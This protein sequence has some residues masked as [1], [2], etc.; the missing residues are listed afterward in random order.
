[1]DWWVCKTGVEMFDALQTCGLAV[2]L[3]TAGEEPVTVRDEG[4]A[5]RLSSKQKGNFPHPTLE[6]L[7]QILQLP[8]GEEVSS[9]DQ[10]PRPLPLSLT[11]VDG[12]LAALY[13][14]QGIRLVSL[15][16]LQQKQRQTSTA[17]TLGLQ[18]IQETITRLKNWTRRY[19]QADATWLDCVLRDYAAVPAP[20]PTFSP[21]QKGKSLTLWMTL[22]PALG[23]STRQPRSD[24]LIALKSNLT[25][26]SPRYGVFLSVIGAARFLR[27]Q[28][29][30]GQ[31]INYYLPLPTTLTVTRQTT[32]PTLP[33]LT[34]P[35]P[36]ALVAHWLTYVRP[37]PPLDASWQAMAYQTLSAGGTRQALSLTRGALSFE[38]ISQIAERTSQGLI[39]SWHALVKAGQDQA[40]Y[41]VARLCD[42]LMNHDRASWLMH[43]RDYAY[44]VIR[45]PDGLR[46]Y[47]VAELQEV[48]QAMT[49]SSTPLSAVLER[50]EGTLRFGHALRLLGQVNH[51]KLLDLFDL[52]ERV[53]TLEQLHSALKQAALACALAKAKSP[54]IIVPDD[55]DFKYLLQDVERHGV[56]LI[57][58]LLQ[59]L[60]VLR[61][62]SLETDPK[63]GNPGQR[64]EL[65]PTPL[66][67]AAGQPRETAEGEF[68]YGQ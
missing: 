34:N 15:A 17:G 33:A 59:I 37:H 31:L 2:L 45:F 64:D 14:Q 55:D 44:A 29:V 13:T 18:K 23:K 8:T 65:S 3:A 25:M 62:P 47:R 26:G 12:L 6:V 39:R 38:W 5:Y 63:T 19:T 58:S 16:E 46:A 35:Y 1:M 53:Q 43:L 9:L 54:F 48:T 42:A 10:M 61:Y 56:R 7:N 52:L 4:L 67:P 22:D 51:A 49:S 30:A 57:A 11:N 32:L 66:E 41:E 20:D 28:P 60:A 24:G 21:I 40:P 68:V 36:Q 50:K 27:A